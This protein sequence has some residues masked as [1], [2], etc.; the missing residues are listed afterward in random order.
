[1]CGIASLIN[2]G[3]EEIITKR[4]SKIQHR[5]PDDEGII[6]FFERN[7]DWDIGDFRY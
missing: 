2:C 5:G 3:N 1:M 6:W 4:P 7:S